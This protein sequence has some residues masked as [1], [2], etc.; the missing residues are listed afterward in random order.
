MVNLRS[1]DQGHHIFKRAIE[2]SLPEQASASEG[3]IYEGRK[4]KRPVDHSCLTLLSRLQLA[5]W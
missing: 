5:I 1:V 2:P 3:N 4:I